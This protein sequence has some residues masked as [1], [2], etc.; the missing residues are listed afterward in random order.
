MIIEVFPYLLKVLRDQDNDG[1]NP[2]LL[3]KQQS[4]EQPSDIDDMAK[5]EFLIRIQTLFQRD[6]LL[7]FGPKA[8]CMDSTNSTNAY[9]FFLITILVLDDLGEG[10]PIAW[11]I[12]NRED[13]A[14]IRQVLI[15]MKENVQF[16]SCMSDDE[17]LAS[18]LEYF[19]KE[20]NIPQVEQWAPCYRV[21]TV[22]NT[23][24]AVEAFHH[25]LKVCYFDKKQNRRID[26]L[27][28]VLHKIARD[29]VFE[30]VLKT[31]KGKMTHRLSEI[32]KRHKSIDKIKEVSE[33]TSLNDTSWNVSSSN[34]HSTYTV[35][36]VMVGN[37][38]CQLCCHTCGACVHDFTCTCI[39]FIVHATV[40]KHIHFIKMHLDCTIPTRSEDLSSS[41]DLNADMQHSCAHEVEESRDLVET[42]SAFDE[43]ETVQSTDKTTEM[44]FEEV[45]KNNVSSVQ[46]LSKCL[47]RKPTPTSAKN[48]ATSLCKKIEVALLNCTNMDAIAT[49]MKHLNAA[50]TVIS[51]IDSHVLS[52][53]DFPT[54]KRVAP[55]TNF[56]KGGSFQ[57]YK[58]AT[59]FI[60]EI[61]VNSKSWE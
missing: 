58:K 51:A 10:V 39:D 26:M 7:Q 45:Q 37:C 40:C 46:Y 9:D 27:L 61:F 38:S 14:T 48:R 12:S 16:I 3:F 19:Q 34:G 25:S 50:Y 24:M 31:Q 52:D 29:K 18:F 42:N 8:I 15:K 4:Y 22:V 13:A 28:H 56:K 59:N 32:N 36:T 5:N 55:N 20:Y 35:T 1:S 2:I 47:Q 23:N 49:G 33:I 6:M 21:A 54:R 53:G 17:D 43:N 41:I 60:K 44:C 57:I 11:I 30:R